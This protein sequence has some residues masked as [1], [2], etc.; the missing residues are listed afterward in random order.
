MDAISPRGALPRRVEIYLSKVLQSFW[1]ARVTS[2]V[3]DEVVSGDQTFSI[4]Q[5]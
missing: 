3:V 5:S 1:P 2:M 4:M